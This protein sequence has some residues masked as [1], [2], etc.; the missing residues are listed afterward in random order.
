LFLGIK[1]KAV[2]NAA[3]K[4]SMW[5]SGTCPGVVKL[6]LEV[7]SFQFLR[8]YQIDFQSGYTSLNSHQQWRSVPLIPTSLPAC[9]I[10]SVFYLS[11]SDQ[12]KM[13]FQSYFDLYFPDD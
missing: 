11:H 10:T 2:M 8:N 3:E 5:H 1:N 12:G 6:G 4:V 9:A 13:E 7:G